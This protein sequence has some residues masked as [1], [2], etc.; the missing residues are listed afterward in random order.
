[1]ISPVIDEMAK[2]HPNVIFVK[3][4]VDEADEISSLCGIECMPT[5]KFYKNGKLLEEFEGADEGQLK[6]CVAKYA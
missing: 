2:T 6:K 1:M 5:F 4:D 3:V